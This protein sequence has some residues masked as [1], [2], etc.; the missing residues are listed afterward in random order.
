MGKVINGNVI[1]DNDI[2][3]DIGEEKL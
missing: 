3:E 2:I 1:N